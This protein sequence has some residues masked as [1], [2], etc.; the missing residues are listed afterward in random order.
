MIDVTYSIAFHNIYINFSDKLNARWGFIDSFGYSY[1]NHN[2]TINHKLWNYCMFLNRSSFSIDL[3]IIDQKLYQP[4]QRVGGILD[5]SEWSLYPME[6]ERVS[7]FYL[8]LLP[9]ID[10]L[11]LKQFW[12]CFFSRSHT[13]SSTPLF[14]LNLNRYSVQSTGLFYFLGITF[15]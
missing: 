1:L 7:R 9:I 4:I 15:Q 10:Y 8:I 14:N 11:F 5:S 2:I 13:N 3:F 6:M 12:L